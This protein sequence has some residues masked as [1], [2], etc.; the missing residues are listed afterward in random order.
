MPSKTKTNRGKR[1]NSVKGKKTNTYTK[2]RYGGAKKQSGGSAAIEINGQELDS[3]LKT[4]YSNDAKLSFNG[5]MNILNKYTLKLKLKR[6][7]NYEEIYEAYKNKHSEL[8]EESG[9]QRKE[10]LAGS[11]K[12]KDYWKGLFSKVSAKSRDSDT[13]NSLREHL[14]TLYKENVEL[15][16]MMDDLI[17]KFSKIETVNQ[18]INLTINSIND[19]Y[20][21]MNKSNISVGEEGVEEREELQEEGEGGEDSQKSLTFTTGT[22]TSNSS[23]TLQSQSPSS[24]TTSTLRKA[25]EQEPETSTSTTPEEEEV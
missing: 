1:N 15:D 7:E 16:K 20:N 22:T 11:K 17:T 14:T 4:F 18:K 13:F 19:V 9:Q 2:K 10:R 5:K 25:P 12:G 24:E 8:R 3:F 23:P 6:L 21:S